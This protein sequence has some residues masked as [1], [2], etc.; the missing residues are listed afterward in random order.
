LTSKLAL[1]VLL[2]LVL[3]L[4]LLV[5][6]LLLYYSQCLPWYWLVVVLSCF[7][8]VFFLVSRAYFEPMTK[9]SVVNYL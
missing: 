5:L 2:V 9:P 7:V 3:V 4:V 1:L 6:Q 8:V